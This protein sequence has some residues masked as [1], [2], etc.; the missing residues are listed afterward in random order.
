M[1]LSNSIS[2]ELEITSIIKP[3]GYTIFLIFYLA[4][5]IRAECTN[6]FKVHRGG[7]TYSAPDLVCE[8]TQASQNQ[9][10]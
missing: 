8:Y 10:Q 2:V 4:V 5:Y 1:Y 9:L 7:G 3:F 6:L